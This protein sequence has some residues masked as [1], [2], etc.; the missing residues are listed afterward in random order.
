MPYENLLLRIQRYKLDNRLDLQRSM[1]SSKP[2]RNYCSTLVTS[3]FA[4]TVCCGGG[5]YPLFTIITVTPY[6][7]VNKLSWKAFTTRHRRLYWTLFNS[8][9]EFLNLLLSIFISS[10]KIFNSVRL[11][12]VLF[13]EDI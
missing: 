11:N 1:H 2:N 4:R 6:L 12:L 9:F 8:F 7:K 5:V 3:T 10:F 13:F